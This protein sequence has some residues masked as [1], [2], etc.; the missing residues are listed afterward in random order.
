MNGDMF[1]KIN[2][3]WNEHMLR[4]HAHLSNIIQCTE[5][6][7]GFNFWEGRIIRVLK[8]KR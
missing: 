5:N 6:Q 1:S 8:I 4:T 3:V 7:L 2:G